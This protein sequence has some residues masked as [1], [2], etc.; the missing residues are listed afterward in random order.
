MSDTIT[1]SR[2]PFYPCKYDKDLYLAKQFE[3]IYDGDPALLVCG[4]P[5]NPNP[6][7]PAGYTDAGNSLCKKQIATSITSTG[8]QSQ[9]IKNTIRT[10]GAE[11]DF[12]TIILIL[13]VLA[14]VSLS[15]L[16]KHLTKKQ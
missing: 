6:Q 3:P 11:N 7:C 1:F 8:S 2:I 16:Y 10:G 9:V 13:F 14:I 12:S 4:S 5:S 15:I